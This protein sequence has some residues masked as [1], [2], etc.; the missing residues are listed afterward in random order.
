MPNI[1]C[2]HKTSILDNS[3][4]HTKFEKI[5]FI[6][7]SRLDEFLMISLIFLYDEYIDRPKLTEQKNPFEYIVP[8]PTSGVGTKKPFEYIFPSPTSGVGTIK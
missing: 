1:T 4:K 5:F 6:S 3:S 7:N 2:S 8:S